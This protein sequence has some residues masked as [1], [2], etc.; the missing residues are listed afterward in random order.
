MTISTTYDPITGYYNVQAGNNTLAAIPKV[1]LGAHGFNASEQDTITA[2]QN[3]FE[4][5]TNQR[6]PESLQ[7]TAGTVEAAIIRTRAL[8]QIGLYG[9]PEAIAA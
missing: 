3:A 8:E 7:H 4:T 2:L 5:V 6:G 9:K 1:F